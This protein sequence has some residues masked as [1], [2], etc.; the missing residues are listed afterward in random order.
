MQAKAGI[1]VEVAY[2]TPQRQWL[3]PCQ[4][5][6]GTT[7][8]EAIEVSGIR[9]KCADIEVVEG[10][11]GIWSR[12]RPLAT[13]LEDGDRVEIYRPLK[14]DPKEVRRRRARQAQG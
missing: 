4:V 10:Q 2:A 6:P 5:A 13:V 11:V 9:D 14:A 7:L 8:A 3:L 1:R 12:V